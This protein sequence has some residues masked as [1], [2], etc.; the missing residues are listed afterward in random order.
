VGAVRE[1]GSAFDDAVLQPI[2][3]GLEPVVD[4]A[5]QGIDVVQD[6]GRAFDDTVIDPIDDALDT[7]GEEVVDPVLQAG[8]D[9]LSEG[10]DLLKEAGYVI[11]DLVDWESLLKSAIPSGGRTASTPT[12]DLFKN[13]I[14]KFKL[15]DS[16]DK[17]FNEQQIQQFLNQDAVAQQN[18][19]PVK[20]DGF[21]NT[22]LFA[23]EEK[24]E[25]TDLFATTV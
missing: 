17:I 21:L 10:E 7:F 16:P 3:T 2:K 14:Y 1:A 8:S 15:K 19:Q 24:E 22:D 23:D 20:P 18:I 25:Y 5:Q 9:V 12:E 13:E 4:V 6:V 11:D